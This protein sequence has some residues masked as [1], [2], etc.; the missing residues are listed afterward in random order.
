MKKSQVIVPLVSLLA[1]ASTVQ[2]SAAQELPALTAKELAFSV[3]NMDTGIDPRVDFYRY[4]S[5]KWQ[6][7]YVRPERFPSAMSFQFAIN[8]LNLQMA[9]AMSRAA[10]EAKAAPKGSPTQLV[11]D[12]YAAYMDTDGINAR[13]M[14][15]LQP[16]LDRIAALSSLKDLSAYMGRYQG[17][18][19]TLLFLGLAQAQTA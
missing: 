18:T 5:G 10:D 2:L 19:G 15:P 8:Q 14:A 1:L 3:E 7:T 9:G 6:D 17:I 11:G 4:A 13:G 16:E 12:Y